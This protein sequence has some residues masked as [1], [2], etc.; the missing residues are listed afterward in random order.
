MT[1]D[2]MR[3]EISDKSSHRCQNRW[4]FQWI[5]GIQRYCDRIESH[6]AGLVEGLR[7]GKGDHPALV[8]GR[9]EQPGQFKTVPDRSVEPADIN[10]LNGTKRKWQHTVSEKICRER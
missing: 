1:V 8:T 2:D 9:L 3:S 4:K 7:A 5:F 6:R 10:D